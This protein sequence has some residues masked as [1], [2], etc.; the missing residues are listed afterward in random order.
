MGESILAWVFALVG[1][2][3][4]GIVAGYHAGR[5]EAEARVRRRWACELANRARLEKASWMEPQER[6]SH[7]LH[8][9]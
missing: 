8:T 2:A 6:C 7:V 4:S 5:E 1:V 3:V 9:R